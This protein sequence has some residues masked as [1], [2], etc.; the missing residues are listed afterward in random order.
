MIA[1][2]MGG[3]PSTGNITDLSGNVC[4]TAFDNIMRGGTRGQITIC[5]AYYSFDVVNVR[6]QLLTGE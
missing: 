6:L 4:T 3:L 1:V 5:T 2:Y